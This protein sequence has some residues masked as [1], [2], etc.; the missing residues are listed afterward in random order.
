M[1]VMNRDLFPPDGD[2]RDSGVKGKAGNTGGTE[3]T[4]LRY[5]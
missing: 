3:K 1:I 5:G 4:V 2:R